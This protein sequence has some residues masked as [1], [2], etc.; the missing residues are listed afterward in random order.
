MHA[1]NR[2]VNKPI[3]EEPIEFLDPVRRGQIAA[4][5]IVKGKP[6]QSDE[7]MQKLLTDAVAIGNAY[8]RV[9]TVFPRDPGLHVYKDTNA[10][11]VILCCAAGV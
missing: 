10:A 4:I 2:R 7:R 6:F 11:G 8:A 9:N 5:G 3:Q 1:G